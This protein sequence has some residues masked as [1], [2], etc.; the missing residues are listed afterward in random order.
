MKFCL[1]TKVAFKEL[2]FMKVVVLVKPE[3]RN[4]ISHVQTDSVKTGIGNTLGK[5]HGSHMIVT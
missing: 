1:P 4:R 5:S 2:W 3:H